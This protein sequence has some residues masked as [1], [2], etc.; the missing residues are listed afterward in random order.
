[1]GEAV[2]TFPVTLESAGACITCGV[3]IVMPAQL[4]E[5]KLKDQTNFFCINGHAQHYTGESEEA[6][7]KRALE[8]EKNR[9]E[10]AERS[11]ASAQERAVTAR[12]AE[13]IARGK[14]KAQA[15][16]AKNGVCPCCTRHFTNLERH[17]ATKH[18]GFAKKDG[19]K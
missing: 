3:Q 19:S 13:A 4:K 2:F 15:E 11:E 10:A 18:P 14:L 7:L 12:K 5:K 16:R 6:K 17:I 1:M 8:F 9:R